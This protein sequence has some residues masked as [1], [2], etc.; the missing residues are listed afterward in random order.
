L[1]P[2]RN[3][4]GIK[5]FIKDL[6]PDGVIAP[7]SAKSDD[8]I[9]LGIPIVVAG[10]SNP[11]L[12]EL[13]YILS[14]SAAIGKMAGEYLVSRGFK[15]FAFCGYANLPWSQERGDSFAESITLAGFEI[16]IYPQRK[17]RVRQSWENE[18]DFM[19]DWLLDLPKPV[20]IMS[21][22]DDRSQ[23]IVEA[24]KTVD[25][26]IPSEVALLGVDN[27][28][29]IC[30]LTNPSLSSV[31]VNAER[32][33]YEGAE[34]LDRLMNREKMA[35]QTILAKPTHIVTRQSTDILAIEDQ[36]VAD[37]VRFISENGKKAIG[38]LD[39]VNA[40]LMSRR[41]IERRF[42]AHL[43]YSIYDEIR[44]VRV[45]HICRMLT[46]TNLSITEVAAAMDFPGVEHIARYFRKEKNMSLMA[47]R[48][49]YGNQ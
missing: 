26:H 12:P 17:R 41:A 28:E 15:H 42:K 7:D 9:S 11:R 33:G 13:P 40:V 6:N 22:N 30:D 49:Q 3:H 20:A 32:S 21:C 14:D 46:E 47:Y 24:C 5:Q 18:R 2:R 1:N 38:V 31:A 36:A 35:G 27:D 23:D 25:L 45:D 39:V 48:K 19:S 29:F 44:R 8:L 34:L 16:H 37:A 43:G 4:K 10:M